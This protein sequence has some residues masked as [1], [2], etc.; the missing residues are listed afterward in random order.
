MEEKAKPDTNRNSPL[1]VE[2]QEKAKDDPELA[3]KLE[4]A[5]R[6]IERYSETLKRLADS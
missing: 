2:L 1:W 5:K 6:V 3:G 4:V